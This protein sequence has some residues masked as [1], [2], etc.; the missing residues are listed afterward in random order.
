MVESRSNKIDVDMD[1]NIAEEL[2][3]FIYTGKVQGLEQI[4]AE[5]L[6]AAVMYEL[7]ALKHM[8]LQELVKNVDEETA[9]K[10]L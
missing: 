6:H 9:A 1:E 5:L 10:T 2:F 4:A 8:C 3:R 7:A